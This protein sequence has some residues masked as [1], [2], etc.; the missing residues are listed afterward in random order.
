[1]RWDIYALGATA[2]TLLV[3]KP[4]RSG[5]E[6][7]QSI[8]SAKTVVDKLRVYRQ[9][10]LETPLTS[11]R[12]LHP[13]IPPDFAA[14]VE[15]CL[16]LDP[17]KRY[18]NVADILS[19]LDRMRQMQPLLCR[20]PWSREYL[21]RRFVRR[22]ALWLV[23]FLAL[24]F[25]LGISFYQVN[26]KVFR[27]RYGVFTMMHRDG[28][29]TTTEIFSNEKEDEVF[30]QG[31]MDIYLKAL[32]QARDCIAEGDFAGARKFLDSCHPDRRGWEWG[33]LAFVVQRGETAASPSAELG[34]ERVAGLPLTAGFVRPNP[35]GF[36]LAVNRTLGEAE[37][38]NVR[39]GK[40]D[41]SFLDGNRP[42][43]FI[44]LGSDGK[45][46]VFL[47]ANGEI[48]IRRMP[49]LNK[50]HLLASHPGTQ[51]IALS[52]DLKRL[53]SIDA[54][55]N[56]TI[57]FARNGAEIITIPTGLSN[58]IAMEFTSLANK[59]VLYDSKGQAVLLQAWAVK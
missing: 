46:V 8:Q 34:M 22:N 54:K 53:A 16:E 7:L 1:V 33:R 5:H 29:Q 59:I 39:D 50:L 27:Q 32:L 15:K 38:I 47:R 3:G 19:D 43:R 37:V 52:P 17:E 30:D 41:P 23:P 31:S 48:F 57:R 28:S 10:L 9:R 24:F 51:A 44:D 58:P 12:S 13:R 42:F 35:N 25:V 36:L 55:G 45:T 26:R 40:P 49:D 2:Y 4:P 11:L 14:I 18:A 20:R 21:L 56:L 6:Q